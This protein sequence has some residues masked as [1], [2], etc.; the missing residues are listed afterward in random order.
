MV[1]HVGPDTLERDGGRALPE[2]PGADRR[3]AALGH[4]RRCTAHAVNGLR[5]ALARRA[6]DR[7]HRHR[8]VGGRLRPARATAGCSATRSTTATS[9]PTRGVAAVHERMPHRRALRAQRAAVPAVQHA[10]PVRRRAARTS[11]RS[12]T[13]RCSSP[14]SF[15]FWLTGEAARRA[16]RTRRRP[17]CSTSARRAGT[18][19]SSRALGHA[20]RHPSPAH[21]PGRAPRRPAARGRRVD[22]REPRR[23]GHR[24]RLARHR[25][26]RRRRADASRMPPPT[27]RA[28]PGGSS[29]SRSSARSLTA[30][31]LAAN[32][33][34]EGGVDGRVRLL[35]N[36]MGLWVLSEAVRTWER[37]G[38]PIDL[39]TLLDS[40]EEVTGHGPGLRRER[41]ALPGARRHAERASTR[42]A[43]STALAP[44]RTR[45]E[46][47]RS[48]VESLAQAFA[49][50]A[51][52]AGRIG[53]VDVRTIHIVGGGSLNELLCQRTAD[54]AGLPVL[55]GPVEATAL[56]NVL[57][58]A[59]ALGARDRARS[60]PSATSSRA[61][62]LRGG[63]SRAHDRLRRRVRL[64]A[65][66]GRRPAGCRPRCWASPTAD[67]T[68]ALDAFGATGTRTARVDDHYRLFSITKPL[69]GIVAARAIERGLLTPDTPLV[70]RAAGVRRGPRRHRAPAP[71]R[72]P[73]LGHRRAAAG[74]AAGSARRAPRPRPRLRRGHRLALLVGRLRRHRG[75]DRARHRR[76][77]G[78]RA[79]ATGRAR[80]APT[81][82]RWTRHPTRTRFRMPR[83]PASTRRSSLRLRH[84][85]AGVI[86]RAAD[87]LALGSA[88]LRDDG[89]IVS[90]ATLAMMLR[91]LTGDIPRLEP[92]PAE[93]GQ[94][95]G[96]T[97][98]LRTRAPGLIDRDMY[99]HGGWSGTEFWVHPTRRS[100]VGAPHE[101]GSAARCRRRRARQRGHR[102]SL[103][104]P[105][106]RGVLR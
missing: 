100:R 33:T 102:R 29:A 60:R 76:D 25:L 10:V 30:E 49:D 26:G 84:P 72:E 9:A 45:A 66:P 23:R 2:R 91:P 51:H 55:A 36:V 1:G 24:G 12:P 7:E 69:V 41:P 83:P 59:R 82:S 64:G 99:G 85:G 37:A 58:Q 18:T 65:P 73:H 67:G 15:G 47:A 44:P 13:P 77:P 94:D 3:R 57:I 6:R 22:R 80:S 63:S 75:D 20:A 19:S 34:N 97:W 95:W 14:T 38:H 5:E 11:S 70:G 89:A 93:R 50:A 31:A 54:R 61:P 52:E 46:Y 98:N 28:A 96:F 27:S 8:L 42:G 21:R 35:H 53:G 105:E 48:I 86:G 68:V 43:P 71:P 90:P 16:A 4:P 17:A 81:A 88:L 78:S 62:T 104:T 39:P 79:S 74:C 103:T 32:F 87:L 101:P 106:R 92:Y 56:G 40:A